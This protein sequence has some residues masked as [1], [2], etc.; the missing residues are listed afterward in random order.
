MAKTMMDFIQ[1]AIEKQKKET[2]TY[3]EWC[4]IRN[5]GTPEEIEEAV[6]RMESIGGYANLQ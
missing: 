1:E 6:S 3:D 5:N 2:I 4:F